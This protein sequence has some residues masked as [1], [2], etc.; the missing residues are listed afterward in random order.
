[1]SASSIAVFA[2]ACQEDDEG[3]ALVLA[4][5]NVSRK[6]VSKSSGIGFVIQMTE[7]RLHIHFM[8]SDFPDIQSW[9]VFLECVNSNVSEWS[10]LNISFWD[11]TKLV[12]SGVFPGDVSERNISMVDVFTPLFDI[13]EEDTLS[14][15]TRI[16]FEAAGLVVDRCVDQTLANE[17][18]PIQRLAKR[19]ERSALLRKRA[20]EIHGSICSVCAISFDRIYGEIGKGFIHVHHLERLADTG[21]RLVNPASDLVPV[22]PNCHSMLHRKNPPL[23]PEE[24]KKLMGVVV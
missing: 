19:Y 14:E 21:K 22:C 3:W 11:N 1:M 6:Y 15:Y 4:T 18:E 24:L 9:G 17:G 12:G 16:C 5:D 7:A 2:D 10:P 13:N 20:I 23:L 8:R